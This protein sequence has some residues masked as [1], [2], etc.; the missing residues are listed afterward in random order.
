MGGGFCRIYDAQRKA[1]PYLAKYM[2]KTRGGELERGGS[3]RGLNVPNS[4][5]CCKPVDLVNTSYP[6]QQV[7]G[8]PGQANGRGNSLLLKSSFDI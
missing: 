2:N 5:T 4:V 1:A 7:P 3:W 8:D 6:A